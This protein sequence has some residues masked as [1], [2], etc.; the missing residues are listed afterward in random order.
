M[1][2]VTGGINDKVFLYEIMMPRH[3]L[4]WKFIFAIN[5]VVIKKSMEFMML[6]FMCTYLL[7]GLKFSQHIIQY[8]RCLTERQII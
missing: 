7:L 6:T 3:S 5:K 2:S 4:S 1:E 8:L